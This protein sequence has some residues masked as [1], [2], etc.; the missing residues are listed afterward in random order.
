MGR[1]KESNDASYAPTEREQQAAKRVMERRANKPPPPSFKVETAAANRV[2]I[3]VD[4]PEPAVGHTLLATTSSP[5]A[6][7][8]S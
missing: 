7:S 8:P 5:A 1:K 3:S 4:H 2:N 6:C